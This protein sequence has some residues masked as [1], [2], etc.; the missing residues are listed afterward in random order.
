MPVDP[1]VA[2]HAVLPEPRRSFLQDFDTRLEG[3]VALRC[4]GGFVVTQRGAQIY[5]MRQ[6]L[7]VDCAAAGV[8]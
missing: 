5:T 6:G 7:K 1:E 3:A 4:L 8:P 2:A